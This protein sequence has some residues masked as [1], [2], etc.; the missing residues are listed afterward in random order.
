MRI[1]RPIVTLRR[2][3]RCTR[4]VCIGAGLFFDNG[5]SDLR[6]TLVA[7][8]ICRSPSPHLRVNLQE[9]EDVFRGVFLRTLFRRFQG[10]VVRANSQSLKYERKSFDLR[11]EF[12]GRNLRFFIRRVILKLSSRQQTNS[13]LKV[14]FQRNLERDQV[15]R[16][17]V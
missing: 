3:A 4:V 11:F 2:F 10:I 6:S 7:N 8:F 17:Y 5:F 14:E 15:A 16:L 13:R 9:L 1:D 12:F